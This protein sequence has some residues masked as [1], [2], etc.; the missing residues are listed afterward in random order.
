MAVWNLGGNGN[1]KE[2]MGLSK[3]GDIFFLSPK[4]YTRLE[5]AISLIRVDGL[6]AWISSRSSVFRAVRPDQS[7]NKTGL[8][9]NFR[10]V[11]SKRLVLS[12]FRFG[13]PESDCVTEHKI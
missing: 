8:D 2:S 1:L 12:V 11:L 7:L 10:L 4:K 9:R 3:N 13:R 5:L 6:A